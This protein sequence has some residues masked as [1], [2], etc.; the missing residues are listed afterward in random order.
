MIECSIE[1]LL[2]Y[3]VHD[4]IFTRRTIIN[5]TN[6]EVFPCDLFCE[7]SMVVKAVFGYEL[8]CINQA[9]KFTTI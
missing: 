8:H 5:S 6:V 4:D 9:I 7:A 1:F 3:V 2:S